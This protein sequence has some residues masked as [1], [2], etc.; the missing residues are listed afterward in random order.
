MFI[1]VNKLCDNVLCFPFNLRQMLKLYLYHSAHEGVCII[2][3]FISLSLATLCVFLA[4]I[5]TLYTPEKVKFS[6]VCMYNCRGC[7]VR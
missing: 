7:S 3:H 2:N 4:I 6:K 5:P 1:Y